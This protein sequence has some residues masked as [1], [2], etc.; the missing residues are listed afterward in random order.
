VAREVIDMRKTVMAMLALATAATATPV[1]GG[2]QPRP[3]NSL[4]LVR[5]YDA[6]GVPPVELKT[7]EAQVREIFARAGIE[8]RWVACVA[9]SK[10]ECAGPLRVNELIVRLVPTSATVELEGF[11]MGQALVTEGDVTGRLLTVYPAM[12]GR[13]ADR[14]PANRPLLGRVIAHEIGHLLLGPAHSTHGLMRP[15]WT[16]IDVARNVPWDWVFSPGEAKRMRER[17]A[18]YA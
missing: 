6:Y 2:T 18:A 9:S 4:L 10:D 3:S 7:A 1:A 11:A 13:L 16:G 15:V 5:T 14:A 17:L 8:V 12:V